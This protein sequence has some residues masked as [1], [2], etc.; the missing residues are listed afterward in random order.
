MK[1][2]NNFGE[3]ADDKHWMVDSQ[4]RPLLCFRVAKSDEQVLLR[5]TLRIE[6]IT[7]QINV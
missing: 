5:Y 3:I 4:Y 6:W 7:L 1:K 2:V